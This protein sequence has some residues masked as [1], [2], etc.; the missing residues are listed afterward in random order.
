LEVKRGDLTIASTTGGVEVCETA[1]P[2][3]YYFP[4][5]DVNR[6][7]LEPVLGHS[8]CEWKGE[9][10]YFDVLGGTALSRAAW[11]YAEPFP[12]FSA[13]AGWVAF[14]PTHLD[15]FVD[16][17]KASAQPGGFYG[18]WITSRFVGPFKGEPG[19]NG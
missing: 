12:E 13:L 7:L 5:G 1:H 16:E 9:A 19:I 2:P 4:P 10:S 17:Q 3:T 15:C 18:G 8:F 14:M 11:T 6:E